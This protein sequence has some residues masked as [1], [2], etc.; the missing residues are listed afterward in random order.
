M[1]GVHKSIS[2]FTYLSIYSVALVS[3]PGDRDIGL[4]SINLSGDEAELESFLNSDSTDFYH[5]IRSR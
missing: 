3:S 5:Q 1:H 2:I 4:E